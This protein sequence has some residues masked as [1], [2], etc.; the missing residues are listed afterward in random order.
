M[1]QA[2]ELTIPELIAEYEKEYLRTNGRKC[3]IT[4]KMDGGWFSMSFMRFRLYD[5]QQMLKALRL[6]PTTEPDEAL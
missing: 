6:R 3:H 2:V 1:K 4:Y 5:L